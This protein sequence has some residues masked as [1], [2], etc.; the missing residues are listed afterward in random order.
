MST[1]SK[2]LAIL[3]A[4]AAALNNDAD[5]SSRNF[6]VRK[7]P[8][9]RG[10]SWE[11]GGFVCPERVSTKPHENTR[12]EVIYDCL[13]AISDPTDADLT[14]SMTTHLG[15]IER[16]ENIFNG[17]AHSQM[18]TSLNE[19]SGAG[20]RVE[21]TSISRGNRILAGA[22]EAGFDASSVIVSVSCT[23]NRYDGSAL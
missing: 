13:I 23:M 7:K 20:F 2:H 17:H 15:D 4:L 18:P 1:T 12:N 6:R 11:K 3:D 10:N 16:I 19:V 21:K 9:N 14:S 5:I 8:Y 22:F